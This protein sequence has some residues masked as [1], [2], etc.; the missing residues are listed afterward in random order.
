MS[1][2]TLVARPAVSLYGTTV[3]YGSAGAGASYGTEQYR[4]HPTVGI[5]TSTHSHPITRYL[6]VGSA[7]LVQKYLGNFRRKKISRKG[8]RMPKVN[9]RRTRRRRFR[10]YRKRTIIAK[11]VVPPSRLV[12]LRMCER[13]LLTGTTGAIA[14]KSIL[15]NG[16][17]DPLLTDSSQQPYY[18]D[19]IKT[20]YR[21]ATVLGAKVTIQFHNTS[22]TVPAIVGL[23]Q[24][25]WDNSQTLSS[26]EFWREISAK[27]RQRLISSD[28]DII[29][30]VIKNSTKK[31]LGL[32]NVRDNSDLVCDI[33]NDG[34]PT[35]LLYNV[36]FAQAVDQA[37]T[38]TVEA[39]ITL[40]QVV[41]LQHPYSPARST[42][43]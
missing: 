7:G 16:L 24:L 29:T 9:K 37:S 12:K 23:Y 17:Q 3:G 38:A 19:Q 6:P 8:N 21:S 25:P 18:Y 40:E 26:Y 30:M 42:D 36:F 28:H 5:T 41:L 2:Y 35:R 33:E 15:Y 22:S 1:I 11:Q 39:I 20:M 4:S 13:I 43:V 32:R 14:N 34:D 31:H 10:R 27:G